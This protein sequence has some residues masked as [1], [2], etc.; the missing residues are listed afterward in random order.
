M[1]SVASL[2]DLNAWCE[3]NLGKSFDLV[4]A[5]RVFGGRY[6]E[7]LQKLNDVTLDGEK[8]HL[9]FNTTEMMTILEP[10][11]I[12]FEANG[13]SIER[14]KKVEFGWHSYGTEEKPQNWQTIRYQESGTQ[15]SIERTSATLVETEKLSTLPKYAIQLVRGDA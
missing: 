1:H 6:G 2:N 9:R 8:L 10:R 15:V 3:L 7:S 5:G 12:S 13:L 14:A 11:S 4:L